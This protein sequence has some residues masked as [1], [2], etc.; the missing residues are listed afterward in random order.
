MSRSME[1]IELMFGGRGTEP[2]MWH[3]YTPIEVDVPNNDKIATECQTYTHASPGRAN[4]PDYSG[5]YAA[6]SFE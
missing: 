3:F 6:G 1:R 4:S 5:A 2:H